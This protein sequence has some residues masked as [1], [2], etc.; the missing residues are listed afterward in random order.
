MRQKA[1]AVRRLQLYFAATLR[2]LARAGLTE[3]EGCCQ[4]DDVPTHTERGDFESSS[5]QDCINFLRFSRAQD[6]PATIVDNARRFCFLQNSN[7]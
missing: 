4:L 6:S 1:L 7:L 2:L 5:E 3:T